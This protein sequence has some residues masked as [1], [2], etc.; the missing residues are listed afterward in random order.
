VLY[1]ATGFV[2]F[3][4]AGVLALLMRIQLAFQA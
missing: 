2:F 3:L 1:I 4:G